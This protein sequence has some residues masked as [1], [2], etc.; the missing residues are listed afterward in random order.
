MDRFSESA[1]HDEFFFILTDDFESNFSIHAYSVVRFL[2][3]KRRLFVSAAFQH[4]KHLFDQGSS[5][6]A[7]PIIFIQGDGKGGGRVVYVSVIVHDAHPHS[8][9]DLFIDFRNQTHIVFFLP[10]IS[11]I[12]LQFRQVDN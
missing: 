12:N 10:E 8:A 3:G 5:Y 2:Y 1:E 6:S 7:T 11:Y 4:T 9:D